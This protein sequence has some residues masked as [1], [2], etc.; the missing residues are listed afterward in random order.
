MRP[1]TTLLLAGAVIAG[2]TGLALAAGGTPQKN[3]VHEMTVQMPNGGIAH[4]RYTGDMAPKLNFVQGAQSPFAAV[5]FGGPSPFAEIER[6]HA[7]MNRQMAA[8]IV[9]ARLMQQSTMS[10]PLYRASLS[11]GGK[12]T[13]IASTGG[14]FCLRSVQITA[15]P[16]GGAPKVVSHTEGNCG[17]AKQTAPQSN[18]STTSPT[19]PSSMGPLQTISYHPSRVLPRS[20]SGI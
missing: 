10:D 16:S 4:I 8:M 18:T 12:G 7:L 17:E 14:S 9:Q 6:M 3:A 5:A 11:G 13:N 19:A 15:T 2:V 20:R 1:M